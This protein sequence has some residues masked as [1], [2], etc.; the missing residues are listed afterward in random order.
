MEASPEDCLRTAKS[1]VIL[2]KWLIVRLEAAIR[3]FP[4]I[5]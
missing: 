1:Y 2:L 4:G 5:T 3:V